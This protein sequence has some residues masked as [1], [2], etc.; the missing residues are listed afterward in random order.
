MAPTLL[1]CAGPTKSIS[2]YLARD[3]T[4]WS[5]H[6]ARS[7]IPSLFAGHLKLTVLQKRNSE[8]IELKFYS[9]GPIDANKTVSVKM[10]L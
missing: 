3:R 7:G 1:S 2:S 6:A 8:K 9:K 4:I 5:G 10:L